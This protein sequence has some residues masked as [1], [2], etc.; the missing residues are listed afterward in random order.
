[1]RDLGTMGE[2]IFRV[3]CADAGLT[4]NPS[5]IDKTGW[6]Y[7]VEFPFNYGLSPEV[8]HKSPIECKIQVKATDDRKGKISISL[9]NLRRLITA[10]M[11][12]FFVFIEFDGK[13]EAQNGYLVHVDNNLISK[14]L[15]RLHSV[16]QSE[17]ENRF[18]KRS[19]TIHYDESHRLDKL[20]GTTLKEL[21]LSHIGSDMAKYV[22]S[23][24]AHL[25]STGYEDG[26]GIINFVTDGKENV[27][28]L[29]DV[30]LGLEKYARIKSF[31]GVKTRFGIKSKTTFID[32]TDGRMQ[33]PEVRPT[34]SGKILFKNGK[35]GV[36]CSFSAKLYIS[37]F[38]T[39]VPREFAKAR[40]EGDFF[41]II[42]YPFNGKAQHS[43]SF[44]E[45]IR[46]EI[47]EFRDAMTLIRDF[48]TPSKIIYSEFNFENFPQFDFK[49]EC[50][51]NEFKFGDQLNALNSAC[52]ILSYFDVR[53]GVDASLNEISCYADEINQ[54]ND[55]INSENLAYKAEFSVDDSGFIPEKEAACISL[56][57]VQIGSH[58][59]GIFVVIIGD[60]LKST[61]DN[62]FEI[63]SN[64]LIIE[65]K[66]FAKKTSIIPINDL[67]DEIPEIEKKY[68]DKY[69]VIVFAS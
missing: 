64:S 14:V 59:F 47:H 38:N 39:M 49:I 67:L 44:G 61:E 8:L 43:F 45:G 12:S 62:K 54:F 26:F 63:F 18:N 32:A 22:E 65:K 52:E 2:S 10:Q 24:N 56:I 16:E 7:F 1:M 4:A 9:S 48:C 31:R 68:S 50:H 51:D 25:K 37:P 55:V 36:G 34:T 27:L 66:L 60:L 11:P 42:F 30:S 69:Q 15:K 29:I 58:T 28:K 13:S 57:S 40:I 23:K 17:Q 21:L 6:D 41:D 19:M 33:M 46:L 20:D 5:E 53:E 3:W 35:F